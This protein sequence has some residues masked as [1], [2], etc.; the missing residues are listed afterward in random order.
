MT[1]T[2]TGKEKRQD[3][4]PGKPE[5]RQLV[6][7]ASEALARLDAGRLEE[8]A[9]C[10]RALNREMKP[11]KA[12][13]RDGAAQELARQAREAAGEFAVFTRVLEATRANLEVWKRLRGL[14][15]EQL[16]YGRTQEPA[17]SW[18]RREA[19]NGNH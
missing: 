13:E 16:E 3:A 17:R 10:C 15:R 19:M 14:D 6:R 11:Q 18:A 9:Q 8:L 12:K 2:E 5:L 1:G 4:S 7:E